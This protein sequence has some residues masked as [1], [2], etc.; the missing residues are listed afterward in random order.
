MSVTGFNRRRRE[1]AELER[2]SETRPP[3][4][5]EVKEEP[6]FADLRNEAREA[7]IEGYG[8]MKKVELEEVL[9]K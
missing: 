6:T 7:G 1:L 8:K 4:R 5:Q 9:G 3:E 2:E